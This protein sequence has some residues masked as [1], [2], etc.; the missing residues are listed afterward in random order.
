VHPIAIAHVDWIECLEVYVS[1]VNMPR[2]KK[3]QVL[4]EVLAG[5]KLITIGKYFRAKQWYMA[6]SEC[7][8]GKITREFNLLVHCNTDKLQAEANDGILMVK[9]PKSSLQCF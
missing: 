7:P 5:N 6:Y 2:V 8:R 1:K 4:V 9:I 3:E